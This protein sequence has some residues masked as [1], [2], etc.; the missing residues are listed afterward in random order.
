V[1]TD[2]RDAPVTDGIKHIKKLQK[3]IVKDKIG[4]IVTLSGRYYV[5]DRDKRWD[6]TKKAYDCIVNGGGEEFTDVLKAI[7]KNYENDKTDEFIIPIKLKGYQ[8]IKKNDSFIFFNFRTDRTRQLTKAIVEDSFEGW[9]RKPLDVYYV[10]M[11]QF[12]KPMKA[13]VAFEDQSL[14]KLLGEI[15][16]KA[17]LKQLRISETEKYAH[18]TFFLNGQ[19]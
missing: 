12:Y 4:K 7:K 11:T 10:A 8:G 19:I 15:I 1:V 6:R 14:Q 3:K 13:H 5:M 2:G 9:E 18:V 16:S 17:G